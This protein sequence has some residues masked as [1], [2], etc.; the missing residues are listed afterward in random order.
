MVRD[1]ARPLRVLMV[2]HL[3]AIME[4]GGARVQLELA[5]VLREHGCHVRV[6]DRPE[7]LG[8]R[9]GR[10][11]RRSQ[12]AFTGAAVRAGRATAHEYDGADAHPANLPGAKGRLGFDGRLLARS[13]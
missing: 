5:E 11:F 12:P 10:R 2:M 9:L 4:L 1:G 8:P 13:V 3:R 7:I 6:L